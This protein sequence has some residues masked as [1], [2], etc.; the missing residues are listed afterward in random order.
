[1]G[2]IGNYTGTKLVSACKIPYYELFHFISF[3]YIS[4]SSA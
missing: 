3:S 4:L 1:M 2:E